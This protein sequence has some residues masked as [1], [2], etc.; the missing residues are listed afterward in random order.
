MILGDFVGLRF[1][2]AEGVAAAPP[3]RLRGFCGEGEAPPG[4]RDPSQRRICL[5]TSART[6][7]GNSESVAGSTSAPSMPAKLGE[8]G[9]GGAGRFFFFGDAL[10]SAVI[11]TGAGPESK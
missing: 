3:R 10:N 5:S 11:G 6:A 2:F 1:F 4:R 7:G 8:A 9:A